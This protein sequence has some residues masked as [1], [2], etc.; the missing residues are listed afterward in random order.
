MNKKFIIK[1]FLTLLFTVCFALPGF[2]DEQLFKQG[3]FTVDDIINGLVD[4]PGI[5]TRSIKSVYLAIHFQINSFVITPEAAQTLDVL[6]KA[7]N[8]E[9]LKKFRFM[10]EG[11]TD[12]TG[13]HKYNMILSQKRAEA[14]SDYL[15]NN[16]AIDRDRLPM[17]GKGETELL[18]GVAPDSPTNR[19]VRII[20]IGP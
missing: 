11:H 5:K 8:S 4:P 10:I 15:V 14:I 3:K 17:K 18:S 16:H 19:R 2:A 12:A 20:N 13:T 1:I 6:G 7:F 9:R